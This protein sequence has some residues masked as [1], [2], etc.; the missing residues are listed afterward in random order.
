MNKYSP[1]KKTGSLLER[2]GEIYD[3]IPAVR[4]GEQ[5]RGASDRSPP[6]AP[7]RQVTPVTPRPI[8]AYDGPQVIVDRD[9]LREAGF[10]VPDGPVTGISEEFRIIKRQLLLAAKGSQKTA[11]V[12]HGERIL[13]CSAHPDEGKTFCA[14]NLA[15]SIAAEK[16]NEVLLVD[17]DFAK[18]SILSSLGLEG[19][20][21]LMDALAD[22][23]LPVENCIIHTDIPG[24]AILPAGD[25][26]NADTEYLASARTEQVLNRLT[27]NNPHRIVIF[28]SPPALSASP[29][30]VLATHVGQVVMVVKADETT[31]TAL[32]DALSLMGGC[33]HI[34]LLLNGT[35]FSPTGRRFGSYYGYGE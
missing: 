26:T 17:A 29:A 32:R 21:G 6:E 10:I 15:L 20:K 3:Y 24:L 4:T 34:Q 31:E 35:K 11:P 18:P 33:E 1:P 27:Q 8:E 19:S 13:I 9:K 23:E 5:N 28:D 30:S 2:A 16:D 22:P 25:Q 14:L 12:R 7:A